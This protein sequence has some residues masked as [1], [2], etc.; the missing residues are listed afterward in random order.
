[1]ASHKGLT[2]T[3][4]HVPYTYVYANATARN[5]A[6]GFV[7]ADVGKLA[8]QTDDNSLWIL[9]ATTPTWVQVSGAHTHA[10]SD[11]TSLIPDL[12]AKAPLASPTLTGTPAAPTASGGTNTTQIATT[13]FVQGEV[14]THEAD[15]TS[16]HGI[17]DTST[18]YRAGGTDVALADGGTGASLTDP[19]AD[20]ILFWDDSAGQLTWLT[21]GT[22]LTITGTTIDASG[23]G[24]SALT[25]EEADGSPTDSA[26]TKIIFPNGTLSIVSHEATYTPAAGGA[27]TTAPYITTAADAGLSA[28]IVIPGL[29]A[30]GDISGAGGGGIGEEYDTGTTGLSWSPS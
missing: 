3:D 7:S 9:T 21:A 8:R 20:R 2:G 28:E 22:N 1:M 10:E 27:P 30:S 6:T 12:A 29:A 18:L 13:A 24:G 4:I 25:V 5:A 23:G 11:V 15:T 17:T 14:A 26:I 19:N 16:V